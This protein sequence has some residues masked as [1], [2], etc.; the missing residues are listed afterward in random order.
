MLCT[1]AG[2]APP[3]RSALLSSRRL[4]QQRERGEKCLSRTDSVAFKWM[5]T[6]EFVYK[7]QERVGV[8]LETPEEFG[9]VSNTRGEGME[10]LGQVWI[11]GVS[12]LI[13]VIN[14]HKAAHPSVP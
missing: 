2:L 6:G 3:A 4:P 12:A 8:K 1:D 13:T 11:C 14:T 7:R 10:H 5:N 9:S